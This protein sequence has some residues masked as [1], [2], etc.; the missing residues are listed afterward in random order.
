MKK[1]TPK[2]TC[3]GIINNCTKHYKTE[4]MGEEYH[5]NRVLLLEA[6]HRKRYTGTFCCHLKVQLRKCTAGRTLYQERSLA[7]K[8][9][10]HRLN[11]KSQLANTGFIPTRCLSPLY[12]EMASRAPLMAPRQKSNKKHQKEHRSRVSHTAC[13]DE[14]RRNLRSHRWSVFLFFI[15]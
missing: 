3:T 9:L 11:P 12:G 4:R 14:F 8:H 1:P 7:K 10:T 5:P 15:I 13:K 2:T 6:L